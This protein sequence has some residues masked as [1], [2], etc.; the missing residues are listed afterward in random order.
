VRRSN[1]GADFALRAAGWN[2]ALAGALH[3]PWI[4]AHLVAPVAA[5]QGRAALAWAGLPSAPFAVTAS[6]ANVDVAAVCAGAILA[7]PASGRRRALGALGALACALF[8]NV[9]RLASLAGAGARAFDLLHLVVWPVAIAAGMFV[10]V[11]TW[12]CW[13]GVFRRT[14]FGRFTLVSAVL[15]AV[16]VAAAPVYLQSHVLLIAAGSV[17][18][19]A[20]GILRLAGVDAVATGQTLWSGGTGVV[21]T[22]ECLATPLLP[23]AAAA[24]LVHPAAAW[25]RAAALA[26]LV[27]A[28]FALGVV[29]LLLVAVP[30]WLVQSPLIVVHAFF[31]ILIAAVCIMAASWLQRDAEISPVRRA[32]IG[33][34]VAAIVGVVSSWIGLADL[35]RPPGAPDPQAAI[36]LLPA[37][38]LA[39]FAGIAATGYGRMRAGVMTAGLVLLAVEAA[40]LVSIVDAIAGTYGVMP[41][42]RDIRGWSIAAPVALAFVLGRRGMHAGEHV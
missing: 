4:E 25:R 26:A 41:Q 29:R 21:V 19:L 16:F 28:F 27:P 37:C 31:E 42:V 1:R 24:V 17:A 6:C 23:I 15:C 33:L 9:A 22:Q 20:A 38:Q 13:N 39:T 8:L 12:L 35:L 40:L 5:L 34:G 18:S 3:L 11:V 2:V 14:A 36:A 30:R 7:Y 10:Y 32:A